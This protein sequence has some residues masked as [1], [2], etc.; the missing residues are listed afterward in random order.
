MIRTLVFLL[1][2]AVLPVAA[3]CSGEAGWDDGVHLCACTV[4][5][6]IDAGWAEHRVLEAYYATDGEPSLSMI[7]QAQ[8]GLNGEGCPADSYYLFGAGDVRYLGLDLA[9]ASG[10]S[11]GNDKWVYSFPRMA[12]NQCRHG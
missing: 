5:A 4:K 2:I 12:L 11:F 1:V 10:Q 7:E 9:C 6:R 3:K 8:L